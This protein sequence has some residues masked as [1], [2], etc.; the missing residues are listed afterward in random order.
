MRHLGHMAHF[1]AWPRRPLAI[2]M[3]G[4]ARD[5]EPLLVVA[6]L[7]ADQIGHGDR[8]VAHWF[9]KRPAG[10]RP[11][12]LLELR[13]GGAVER[14]MARIVDPRRD[15]VDQDARSVTPLVEHEH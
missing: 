9:S 6:D 1:A 4:G 7:L 11:D 13:D 15:L 2:E 8:A 12:M 10:D 14:P 5:A 3:N